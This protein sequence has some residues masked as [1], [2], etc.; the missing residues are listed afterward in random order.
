MQ[1]DKDQQE[2]NEQY[3]EKVR[4]LLA[5]AES[6]NEA[7]A[8]SALLKAQAIIAKYKI[9]EAQLGGGEE[10]EV[11]TLATG[12]SF[13]SRTKW[14]SRLAT[15]LADHMGCFVAVS[16]VKRSRT[17]DVLL[18]GLRKDAEIAVEASRYAV[19]FVSDF[20]DGFRKRLGKEYPGAP[21]RRFRDDSCLSYGL[22]FASG[23]ESALK[24]QEEDNEWGLV[25]VMPEAVRQE[26]AG[27]R[28][29]SV[30]RNSTYQQLDSAYNAGFQEGARYNAFGRREALHW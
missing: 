9:E 1:P 7:E 2:Q 13:S 29:V 8:R 12:I 30:A 25:L 22:G 17:Y 14:K 18:V 26:R 28:K 3:V 19:Q 15:V 23:L 5:L 16:H 10:Q 4:K 27:Y 20:L 24:E 21:F 11:V 6:P